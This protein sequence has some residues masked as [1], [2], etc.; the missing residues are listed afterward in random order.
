[1]HDLKLTTQAITTLLM[2]LEV[3]NKTG[4]SLADSKY[5]IEL[6]AVLK[7]AAETEATDG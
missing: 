2:S 5:V 1:M 7:Q 4:L 6:A 3:L